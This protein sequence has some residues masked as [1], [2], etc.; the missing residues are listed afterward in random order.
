MATAPEAKQPPDYRPQENQQGRREGEARSQGA[1]L[2]DAAEAM[3]HDAREAADRGTDAA[4]VAADAVADITR[5]AAD[6]GREAVRAGL[7]VVAG[8]QEPIAD[9]T[10]DQSRQFL[11]ATARVTSAYREAAEKTAE[12]VQALL[13]AYAQLGRGMQQLQHSYFDLLHQA[14][15][16]ATHKPQDLLR[17][18]SMVEFAELQRDLYRDAISTALDGSAKMFQLAGQ[19][20]QNAMQPLQGR[21]RARAMG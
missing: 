3:A 12:D 9:A 4:A 15:E 20:A 8:V 16:R 5:R 7:R 1:R 2:R 21:A 14:I 17:C 13:A 19:V 6:H 11:S 10:Y 18:T